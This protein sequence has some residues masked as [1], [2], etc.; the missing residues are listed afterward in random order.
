VRRRVFF[1][2]KECTNER[3]L[4]ERGGPSYRQW[5]GNKRENSEPSHKEQGRRI[6]KK[7]ENIISL[8]ELGFQRKGSEDGRARS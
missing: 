2:E 4:G 6:T 8:P 7:K 1:F 3:D 5:D